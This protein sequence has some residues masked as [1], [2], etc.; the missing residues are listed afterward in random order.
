MG[1]TFR[2][3]LEPKPPPWAGLMKRIFSLGI[4]NA[5]VISCN[6]RNGASLATQIVKRPLSLSNWAWAECGSIAA[7]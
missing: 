5:S 4:A 6:A 2:P 1:S 3:P 7:C